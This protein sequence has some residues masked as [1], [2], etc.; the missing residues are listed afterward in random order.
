MKE[1][2]SGNE[3]I[4][5]GAYEAGVKVGVGYPGTPST[6]VLENLRKYDG[7]YAEWSPNEKVAFEVGAGASVMGARTIVTMKHVGVNVAADPLMSFAYAGVNGGFILY[8]ADDP[9]MHSSQDEQDNRLLG[10]FAKIPV[11]EPS[12]SQEAKDFVAVAFDISETYDTPVMLRTTTRIAHSQSM[13]ELVERQ[14]VPLKEYVKNAPKNVMVPAYGRARRVVVEERMGKLTEY[15]AKTSLNKVEWGN[16]EFGI[17]TSGICYHYIKEA[18]PEASI[19]KLGLTFPLNKEYIADFVNQVDRVFVVEELEPFLEDAIT[20]MGLQVS[21]KG[22]FPNIGELNAT[23][24]KNRISQELGL[25]I[26]EPEMI[27]AADL[28]SAPMRPPVLCAGCPHRAVFH[29]LRKLKLTVTGDIGC[30]TLGA[31][32][33]LEA[34]DTTICMG[35]S[36]GMAVGMEKANPAM[37]GKIVAVIGDSTFFHSGITGLVDMVYN[38]SKGTVI[39]LDNSTTAMTGHQDNPSTGK[40]LKGEVAT[41]INIAD[42]AKGVGVWR[43]VTVDPFKIDQMEQILKEELAA[44]E[45]SVIIAK[46]PCALL[47]LPEINKGPLQ[48]LEDKC[49][50]CK[51]CVSIGCPPIAVGEGTV[52]LDSKSCN[53]CSLC[54]QLCKFDAIVKAGGADE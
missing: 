12:D 13:V 43:V 2:L 33:P 1:L 8:S 35:A 10:K 14:D 45:P 37:S 40:T 4:A 30:Y 47:D 34:I 28:P 38:K 15:A 23:I 6:E 3:A 41:V 19:L 11:V 36:I 25:K 32:A 21:G 22:L 52:T 16:K 27:S 9:G 5:R 39:V 46:S 31:S 29:V 26:A 53:G 24:V 44:P 7:I 51:A 54:A 17:I 18:F 20:L 42:V 49:K 48:I 50:N